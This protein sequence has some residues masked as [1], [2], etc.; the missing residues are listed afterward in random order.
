MKTIIAGG[1]YY[2]LTQDDCIALQDVGI[3]EVVSGCQTGADTGGE[4]WA[5]VNRLP[6]KPFPAD[7]DRLGHA[8][9]PI[10]NRQMAQYAEA[11]VL[12]PGDRGTQSMFDEATKAG[13]LIFDWRGVGSTSGDQR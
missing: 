10:R 9:G 5:K 1:R 12:F 4:E 2:Q 8:A 11:V 7:W 13:L 6:I 3:T